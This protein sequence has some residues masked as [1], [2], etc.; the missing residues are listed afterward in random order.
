LYLKLQWF[1]CPRGVLEHGIQ[2]MEQFAWMMAGA[3][4]ACLFIAWAMAAAQRKSEEDQPYA[5]GVASP[6]P[7]IR[8]AP[9][10]DAEL[11]LKCDWRDDPISPSFGR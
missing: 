5:L 4:L 2:I 3:S 11:I 6:S 1:H 9:A 8:P 10:N 7:D